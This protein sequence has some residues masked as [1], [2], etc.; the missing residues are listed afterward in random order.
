MGMAEMM[1]N[2]PELATMMSNPVIQEEFERT[3][4]EKLT[5]I[6]ADEIENEDK[7]KTREE[8]KPMIPV[9]FD[10]MENV[11]LELKEKHSVE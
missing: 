2:D 11:M 6:F 4:V 1:E 3:L 7:I 8:I 9:I 10:E 5:V